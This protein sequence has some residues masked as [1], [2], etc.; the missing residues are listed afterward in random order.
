MHHV[1]NNH[2]PT[3]R[4]NLKLIDRLRAARWTPPDYWQTD[5]SN[6]LVMVICNY[7]WLNSASRVLMSTCSAPLVQTGQRKQFS[8]FHLDL[9]STTL[10]CTSRLAKVKVDPH[11]KIKVKVKLFK[12]ESAHRQRTDGRYQTYY[13]PCYAVD[14]YRDMKLWHTLYC[15]MCQSTKILE[16]GMDF[17]TRATELPHAITVSNSISNSTQHH[18]CLITFSETDIH[19]LKIHITLY[20]GCANKKTIPY[21]SYCIIS[22]SCVAATGLVGTDIVNPV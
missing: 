8:S 11:A 6:G 3:L 1:Y 7:H 18:R 4:G 15:Q 2:P 20:T 13:S 10:T 5:N 16:L 14:N 21:L 9:W 19:H 12:Q 17:S 22:G